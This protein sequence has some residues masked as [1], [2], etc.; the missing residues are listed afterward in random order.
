MSESRS[1]AD[2]EPAN[3][4]ITGILLVGFLFALGIWVF[5]WRSEPLALIF[6]AVLVLVAAPAVLLVRRK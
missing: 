3:P 6:T 5:I 1:P 2:Q 4:L